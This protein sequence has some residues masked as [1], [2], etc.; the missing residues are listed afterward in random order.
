MTLK[1]TQAAREAADEIGWLIEENAGGIAHWIKLAEGRH[2]YIEFRH[3]RYGDLEQNRHH[4]PID[5]TKDTS[6]ALRFARKEDAGAFMHCFERFL[7]S[8][9]VTEH[10]WHAGPPIRALKGQ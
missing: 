3:K 6:E 10:I 1:I 2:P 9:F 4:I 8:P 7:L 5:R